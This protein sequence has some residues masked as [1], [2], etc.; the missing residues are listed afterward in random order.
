LSTVDKRLSSELVLSPLFLRVDTGGPWCFVVTVVFV[1]VRLG[2]M[3]VTGEGGTWGFS[4]KSALA[5]VSLRREIVLVIA[6]FAVTGMF[7]LD[8]VRLCWDILEFILVANG[9]AVRAAFLLVVAAVGLLLFRVNEVEPL[10]SLDPTELDIA[11]STLPWR[12][13][14]STSTLSDLSDGALCCAVSVHE[15]LASELSSPL[16]DL[17]SSPPRSSDLPARSGDESFCSGDSRKK[18]R[19]W[20]LKT[21]WTMVENSGIATCFGAVVAVEL[22]VPACCWVGCGVGGLETYC[23]WII[24]CGGKTCDRRGTANVAP[25]FRLMSGVT[26]ARPDVRLGDAG[27]RPGV[28]CEGR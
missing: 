1:G 12:T 27:K 16:F 21:G 17:S 20:W 11:V 14:A 24:S 28:K 3:G 23:G 10:E 19:D 15:A 4:F 2:C 22:K 26:L 8:F 5:P 13:D 7:E 25:V 9:R 6:R 18:K